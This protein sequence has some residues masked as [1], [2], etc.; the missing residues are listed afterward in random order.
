MQ[1]HKMG[2][3]TLV[4]AGSLRILESRLEVGEEQAVPLIRLTH[5]EADQNYADVPVQIFDCP[6]G[7]SCPMVNAVKECDFAVLV[8]E[9]TPFGL[10][11]L[12]L[13]VETLSLLEKPFG[14][15]INRDGTGN[16]EVSQ[17]CLEAQI[18]V[19]GRIPFD[20]KFAAYY[21]TGRLCY[22]QDARITDALQQIMQSIG[23]IT[24]KYE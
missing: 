11:D 3:T 14:V 17:F 4:R 10:N 21:A 22:D 1:E 7:T 24:G 16:E 8:T 19:I 6:P 20:K 12:K 23:I 18:A 2:Q 5:Q 15:V 9:P 13:A